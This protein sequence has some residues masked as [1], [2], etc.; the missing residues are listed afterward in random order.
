MNPNLLLAIVG[1]VALAIL[2]IAVRWQWIIWG[3]IFW[4]VIEGAF[5]KWVFSGFQAEIYLIK[6]ALLLSAYV[7]FAMSRIKSGET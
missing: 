4:V 2:A 1:L 6:D 3:V 5:R 7:G